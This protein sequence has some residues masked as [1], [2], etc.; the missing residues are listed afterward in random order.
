MN[1]TKYKRRACGALAALLM[2][3]GTSC[4]ITWRE[5]SPFYEGTVEETTAEE[6]TDK[7]ETAMAE[8]AE[9]E[10]TEKET[11]TPH[12]DHNYEAHTT[13]PTATE[14]G[15]TTYTCLG[16]GH[17]YTEAVTPVSFSITQGNRDK[18]G[19]TDS[20]REQLVIPALFQDGQT[21]YRVTSIGDFAFQKYV[22]LT[23]VTIPDSV[24]S[25]GDS[26]FE[27]CTS[28]SS[29]TIPD[30]V[31]SI[32]SFAFFGCTSLTSIYFTGTQ[33]E[34]NAISRGTNWDLLTPAYTIHYNYT[35]V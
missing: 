14:D 4:S 11:E 6:E 3:S 7:V 12:T 23:S 30:S 8:T 28:L 10:T 22:S 20:S 1:V 25:I 35:P 5:D 17:S 9:P 31:T 13:P 34:W 2:L 32:R 18:I 29:V 19:F 33:A 26:A 21:W 16:C 15:Y 24:T 27:N